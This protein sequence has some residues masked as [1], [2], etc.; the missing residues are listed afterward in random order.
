MAFN[1]RWEFQTLADEVGLEPEKLLVHFRRDFEDLVSR[2]PVYLLGVS[3]SGNYFTLC[4]ATGKKYEPSPIPGLYAI[5]S[6]HALVY[7]GKANDLRRRQ[8]E[9]PDNT[10]DS[11]KR[12]SNQGRAIIKS[13]LHFG[14]ASRLCLEPLF[15]QLYPNDASLGNSTFE[16][17]YRVSKHSKALEGAASLFIHALHPSMIAKARAGGLI[18][19]S[20]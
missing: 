11:G 20:G 9:D 4:D 13:L 15:M 3:Q 12:F 18:N 2:C 17:E 6:E 1:A 14:W 7:F 10:A 8:I 5:F 19:D 16:A